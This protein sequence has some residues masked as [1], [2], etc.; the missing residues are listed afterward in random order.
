MDIAQLLSDT[1][2]IEGC[3]DGA[4][5]REPKQR[6]N[7]WMLT[8]KLPAKDG[9]LETLPPLRVLRFTTPDNLFGNLPKPAA[10][11]GSAVPPFITAEQRAE[12]AAQVEV[13]DEPQSADSALGKADAAP[14]VKSTS[15]VSAVGQAAAQSPTSEEASDSEADGPV[16]SDRR[17]RR[18]IAAER[19]VENQLRQQRREADKASSRDLLKV[20]ERDFAGA[21]I[22]EILRRIAG[23]RIKWNEAAFESHDGL[24]LRYPE[25]F[26]RTGMSEADLLQHCA[27]NKW[28][29]IDSGSDRKTTEREFPT[30]TRHKCIILTQKVLHAWQAI[31]NEYPQVLSGAAVDLYG[32]GDVIQPKAEPALAQPPAQDQRRHQV[33]QGG[34]QQGQRPGGAQEQGRHGSGRPQQQ[35]R[36]SVQNGRGAGGGQSG[37]GQP[38]SSAQAGQ[39]G[40]GGNSAGTAGRQGQQT[41]PTAQAQQNSS[42]SQ[43]KQAPTAAPNHGRPAQQPRGPTTAAAEKPARVASTPDFEGSGL[44]EQP[45]RNGKPLPPVADAT[46]SGGRP[47][48][49]PRPPENQDPSRYGAISDGKTPSS[50]LKTREGLIKAP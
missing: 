2:F 25:S 36:D 13:V 41:R 7:M 18:D 24:V 28:L 20:L 16:I 9:S 48:P 43:N 39:S 30:G 33:N 34:Q 40:Q 26:G 14:A 4:E 12:I 6:S 15:D 38:G 35:E 47:R 10:V 37:Q 19:S 3:D 50:E 17:N 42:P 5:G 31:C 32:E 11:E 21:A 23:G 27:T 44:I 49:A 8:T 29:V 22:A 45:T 1:G 46:V